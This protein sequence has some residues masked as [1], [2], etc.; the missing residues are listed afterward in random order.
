VQ[1]ETLRGIYD[2]IG[3]EADATLVKHIRDRLFSSRSPTFRRGAI[4][5]WRTA[6]DDETAALFEREAGSLLPLLGYS[7]D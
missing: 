4:G 3:V 7:A 2:H 1:L 5:Q 6:F